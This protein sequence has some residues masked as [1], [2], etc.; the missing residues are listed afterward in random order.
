[1][2]PFFRK[3][4]DTFDYT[5]SR[6]CVSCQQSFTGRFCNRCGEKVVEPQ[7]RSIFYFLGNVL[8]ALTFLDSKFLRSLRYL[9]TR[10]G[11]ITRNYIEGRRVSFMKPLSLFFIA[12]LVYFLFSAFDTFNSKLT[13]QMNYLPHSA[14][15]TTLVEKKLE[16]RQTTLED[17]TILYQ[18]QSTTIA[19]LFLLG[20]AFLCSIPIML[21]NLSKKRYYVDHLLVAMEYTTFLILVVFMGIYLL[22]LIV[23][24]AG[25]IFDA[26]LKFLFAERYISILIALVS[27]IVLYAME[28]RVYAARSVFAIVKTMVLLPCI[29]GAL[30]L[31]RIILF[32]ITMWTL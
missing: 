14:L 21:L 17:F 30:Q 20:F 24:S 26:D 8:N 4:R 32:F 6:V 18:E 9:A 25:F 1:M 31:Y 10:P 29:F 11:Y 3:R 5:S 27:G 22:M 23:M 13:T 15:A 28:R 2:K 16:T 19:K 7:E 12:N